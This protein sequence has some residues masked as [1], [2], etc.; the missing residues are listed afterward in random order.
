M[1]R[2]VR[3]TAAAA[4]PATYIPSHPLAHTHTSLIQFAKY[5]D[6][7]KSW[8]SRLARHGWLRPDASHGQRK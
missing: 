5:L 6:R 7:E 4:S 2:P 8:T 3:L 1:T